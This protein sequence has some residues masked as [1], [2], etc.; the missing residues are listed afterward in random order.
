MERSINRWIT[1]IIRQYDSK[2]FLG[3]IFTPLTIRGAAA[4]PVPMMP[5]QSSIEIA[6]HLKAIRTLGDHLL[7]QRDHIRW[8]PDKDAVSAKRPFQL[9]IQNTIIYETFTCTSMEKVG[10]TGRTINHDTISTSWGKF[11]A[12]IIP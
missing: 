5:R 3:I 6:H 9:R 7:Q 4:L 1:H 11:D 12:W 8:I 10:A 2:S